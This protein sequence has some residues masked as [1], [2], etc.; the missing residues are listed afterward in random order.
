M[1]DGGVIS[2]VSRNLKKREDI[3]ATHD[4]EFSLVMLALKL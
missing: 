3:Y 2:Y 4:L 1:Q